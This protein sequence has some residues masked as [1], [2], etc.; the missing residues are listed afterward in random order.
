MKRNSILIILIII[1]M[2][3]VAL[4]MKGSSVAGTGSLIILQ[5]KYIDY[6][7]NMMTSIT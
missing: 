5:S 7:Y 2:I 3:I 6:P 1:I 4:N